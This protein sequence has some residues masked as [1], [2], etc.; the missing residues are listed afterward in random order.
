MKFFGRKRTIAVDENY[1]QISEL[2]RFWN[3]MRREFPDET[4]VGLGASMNS[5]SMDYYIG[6]IGEKL[7]D[8]MDFIDLPGDDW[9]EFSCKLDDEKIQKMYRQIY[10]QGTPDY[11]IE[12]MTT[13][14]FTTRIH[15]A[16]KGEEV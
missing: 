8:D 10:E 14:T 3:E 12:S 2:T 6:K 5:E 16:K 7:V 1:S 4:L 13:N 9:S 11:E 15:F